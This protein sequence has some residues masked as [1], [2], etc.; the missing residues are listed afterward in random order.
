MCRS[1]LLIA[2][3][4]VSAP[5]L[6]MTHERKD[7]RRDESSAGAAV[8][9]VTE[10][11]WDFE[12]FARGGLPGLVANGE[13]AW[14]G[15]V[16][17]SSDSFRLTFLTEASRST[18]EPVWGAG[19]RLMHGRL[20][21]E[22]QYVRIPSGAFQPGSLIQETALDPL[23]RLAP[24]EEPEDLLIYQ[25]IFRSQIAAGRPA[26][27]VGL[28][29]GYLR[30]PTLD[31]GRR[32]DILL[33]DFYAAEVEPDLQQSLSNSLA[34]QEEQTG[35]YSFLVAGSAGLT[36]AAGTFFVRP[37][38]DVLVGP[39]HRTAARWDVAGEFDLPDIGHQWV[40]LGTESVEV[41]VRPLFVLFSVDI[42]W[43]SR[44]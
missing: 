37:R 35:R 39:K 12:V 22:T 15:T 42:G 7:Q 32:D 1:L 40:D 38:V 16:L 20:G 10:A 34:L 33:T 36:L 28:G 8:A 11:V 25:G 14:A 30:F 23:R 31:T 21:F 43:S 44:R 19:F 27:F 4:G 6:G 5:A 9:P 18:R 41:S 26:V 17:D 2:L 24:G 29:A 13:V 3:F